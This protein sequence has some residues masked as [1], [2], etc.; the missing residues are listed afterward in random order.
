MSASD[1]LHCVQVIEGN[2]ML[3]MLVQLCLLNYVSIPFESN[4]ILPELKHSEG[5]SGSHSSWFRF[6]FRFR[7]GFRFRTDGGCYG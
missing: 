3:C 7:F 5:F 1:F 4:V 2:T 6:R